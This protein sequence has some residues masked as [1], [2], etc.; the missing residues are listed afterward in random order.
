MRDSSL[1]TPTKASAQYLFSTQHDAVPKGPFL[2]DTAGA[3]KVTGEFSSG[4]WQWEHGVHQALSNLDYSQKP[5]MD[6]F[7]WIN[8]RT[9]QW[10]SVR[11]NYTISDSQ[12]QSE[13]PQNWDH[14]EDDEWAQKMEW[15]EDNNGLIQGQLTVEE[16]KPLEGVAVSETWDLSNDMNGMSWLNGSQ[17]D[18]QENVGA[19]LVGSSRS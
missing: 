9:N 4:E 3:L 19:S 18:A 1:R 5:A 2:P 15:T 16:S 17:I 12:Q 7:E 14:I 10:D 8:Q 6:P 11:E 13:K